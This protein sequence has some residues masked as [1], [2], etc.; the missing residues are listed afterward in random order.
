MHA[1]IW[2]FTGEPDD[3]VRAYDA[4]LAEVPTA[5][6]RLHL[7][8]RAPDGIVLVDTCPTRE[9]AEE[10]VSDPGFRAL[11]ESHG[12]PAPERVDQFPVH[13]ALVDGERVSA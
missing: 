10:F 4:A 6:M 3:L 1:S 5:D 7:C 2:K 13:L 8:L 9:R 11:L 12:L